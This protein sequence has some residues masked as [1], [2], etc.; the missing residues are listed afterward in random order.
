MKVSG[1]WCFLCLE[2]YSKNKPSPKSKILK[3]HSSQS[4]NPLLWDLFLSLFITHRWSI[5]N[6]TIKIHILH[7]FLK[8][9]FTQIDLKDLYNHPFYLMIWNRQLKL[10]F[11]QFCFVNFSCQWLYFVSLLQWFIVISAIVM[12]SPFSTGLLKQ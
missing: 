9:Q 4:L 12:S 6:L 10:G 5:I 1:Y 3:K 7:G 11:D 2:D 8:K